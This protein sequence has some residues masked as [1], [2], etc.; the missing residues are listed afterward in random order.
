MRI[1]L[2]VSIP[3][4]HLHFP[5]FG[6]DRIQCTTTHISF[7]HHHHLKPSTSVPGSFSHN[8]YPLRDA[9]TPPLVERISSEQPVEYGLPLAMDT[10][11]TVFLPSLVNHGAETPY[12]IPSRRYKGRI[13][14]G[15]RL[16]I[17][18]WC[19]CC[20]CVSTLT[21]IPRNFS[22]FVSFSPCDACTPPRYGQLWARTTPGPSTLTRTC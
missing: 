20:T 5:L 7:P 12:S 17:R 1:A 18:P 19:P 11:V 22:V 16:K 6:G 4:F 15:L 10:D 2:A 9:N 14:I 8:P 13:L 21:T 3:Q